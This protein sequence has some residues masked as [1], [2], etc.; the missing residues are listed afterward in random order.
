MVIVV[1]C[2]KVNTEVSE[3]GIQLLIGTAEGKK[4]SMRTT[5]AVT[6]NKIRE[7]MFTY[8]GFQAQPKKKSSL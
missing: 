1:Y 7:I 3:H 8:N 2:L 4:L 6:R 5:A